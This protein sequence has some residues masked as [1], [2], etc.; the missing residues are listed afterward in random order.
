M[1]VKASGK[2]L[3]TGVQM[4]DSWCLQMWHKSDVSPAGAQTATIYSIR[5]PQVDSSVLRDS[6]LSCSAKT[7]LSHEEKSDFLPQ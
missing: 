6:E 7:F 2:D 1:G 4:A 3:K 5:A